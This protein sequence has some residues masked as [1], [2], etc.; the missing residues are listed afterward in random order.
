VPST[1][2][3][4]P[5]QLIAGDTLV[6]AVPEPTAYPLA[7][8]WVHTL[9]L[10]AVDGSDATA[11]GVL[12]DGVL[13]FT[14]T[15][16]NTAALTAGPAT[17]ARVATKTT[18]RAT[19]AYGV[20]SVLPDPSGDQS[21]TELAHVQRK[22][23]AEKGAR[24]RMRL[25]RQALRDKITEERR[26]ASESQRLYNQQLA[27]FER[28]ER[29]RLNLVRSIG[30]EMNRERERLAREGERAARAAARTHRQGSAT[31][32]RAISAV[33]SAA[34]SV[35]SNVH[36]QMVDARQKRL[37]LLHYIHSSSY[38]YVCRDVGIQDSKDN[39]YYY[40][41]LETAKH[42]IGG[43]LRSN[44]ESWPIHANSACA[45]TFIAVF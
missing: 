40:A 45:N 43:I 14:V 22:I 19:L 33:G 1:L 29:Q 26:A 11:T 25:A 23:A 38:R 24:D 16:L 2:T 10:Q 20:L 12:A 31:G 39:R 36:G 6:V 7:D 28:V 35:G 30:R 37:L 27:A 8:A 18:Q 42:A 5:A 9:R 17:W 15:A 21:T 34:M 44:I 13:T 41:A 32:G 3:A 4:P